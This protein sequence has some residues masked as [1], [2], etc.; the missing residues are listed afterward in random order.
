M[1]NNCIQNVALVSSYNPYSLD[2]GGLQVHLLLLEKGL[3]L[4]GIEVATRYYF[5]S[6]LEKVKLIFK[7]PFG[8]FM[9]YRYRTI[10]RIKLTEEFFRRQSLDNFQ[11]INAH[12]VIA[13][14]SCNTNNLVL[15]LHGY[16]T[17]EVINYRP[18]SK[19]GIAH[20]EKIG[21]DI[22][23]RA[24]SKAKRIITVDSRIKKY[25]ISEF[26]FPE[27]KIE[28]IFN[29][30]DIDIFKPVDKIEKDLIRERL[31][32][33]K[34]DFIVFIPRRYVEKNG[35]IYAA[36]A[37]NIMKN[38]DVKFVFAGVG[39]LK[40]RIID[41]TRGNRNVQILNGISHGK[42]ADYYKACDVVLIPSITSEGIEEATSLSMLEGMSCGKIV[43]C[44]S[45]GGMKEVIIHGKNGFLIEQKSEDAIVSI[46][47]EIIKNY[48]DLDHIRSNARRYIESNHS[49]IIHARRFLEVYIKVINESS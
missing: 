42:I 20:I 32:W 16:F 4:N 11:V 12:D 1:V 39:P 23:K 29:A 13:G 2:I 41:L 19:E 21:I 26:S 36:K 31:G 40:D 27:D 18:L 46:I 38:K 9:D 28:V 3:K 33:S 8:N 44:T 49:H 25:V 17:R 47:E 37:A 5:F 7:C 24:I 15:T 30:V 34:N 48:D 10:A 6:N 22:E 14:A 35:V 43:I 45:I